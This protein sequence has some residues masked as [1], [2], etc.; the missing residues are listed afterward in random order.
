MK[1][2]IFSAVGIPMNFHEDYDAS[3]HWRYIKD[4][5][6]YETA[7]YQYKNFDIEANS[8]DFLTRDTGWKWKMAKN[9]V[10]TYDYTDYEYIGFLDD[11]LVTDIQSINRA[12]EIARENHIK[13][14]QMSL[15]NDSEKQHEV[16]FNDPLMKYTVTNFVEGMG[17]FIHSSLMPIV[18]EF[19]KY[20]EIKSGWGFDIVLPAILKAKTAVI[21]EVSMHHVPKHNPYYDKA[22]AFEEMYHIMNN[23]YPK[24]MKEYY[25][26][27]CG[28]YI[29][30]QKII[31]FTM[32][33]F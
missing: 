20:H 27:D 2:L 24:F 18:M 25:G 17:P 6:M 26:E 11:D 19:W 31:E 29:E 1:S 4:T 7:V 30:P 3:N 9:F 14:F 10:D 21:H 32:R 23:V 13:L 8:Y 22:A 33:G 28:P 12:L 15:N 16:T 5:R